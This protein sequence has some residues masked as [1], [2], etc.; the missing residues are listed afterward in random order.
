MLVI[1]Y[2]FVHLAASFA[3]TGSRH[4]DRNTAPQWSAMANTVQGGRTP[5]YSVFRTPIFVLGQDESQGSITEIA[6]GQ[7]SNLFYLNKVH[8]GRRS[9]YRIHWSA[10]PLHS[11]SHSAPLRP[12]CTCSCICKQLHVLAAIWWDEHHLYMPR[13]IHH[14][15]I[16][17][18]A[19]SVAV[20]HSIILIIRVIY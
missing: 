15:S 12:P 10:T 6:G 2:I 5:I 13:P 11:I 7:K 17:K 8:G 14:A 18:L 9:E 1:S 4:S 20:C 19:T 3:S 16:R